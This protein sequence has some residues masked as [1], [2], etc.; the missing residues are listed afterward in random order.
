MDGRVPAGLTRAD[1]RK[2]GLTVGPAF[3]VLAGIIFW[4]GHVPVAA[5]FATLGAA[6]VLV[7]LVAPGILGP[8]YRGWMAFGLALSKITTPIILGLMYFLVFLPFGVV[9]RAFGR[10]PMVRP[11][12]DTYWVSRAST[13]R[14]S[15][16]NRQF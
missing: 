6:L 9:M 12:G 14:R 1:K 7:G 3:L 11:A 16:L 8:V 5:V 15:N 2:F 4:R 10:N 13:A